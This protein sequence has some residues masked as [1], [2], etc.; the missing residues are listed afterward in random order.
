PFLNTLLVDHTSRANRYTCP[1]VMS[2][3]FSIESRYRAR[4]I[5][6]LRFCAKPFG[7]T[8]TSFAVKYVSTAD[9][10]AYRSSIT[11]PVTSVSSVN[12]AVEYTTTSSRA[13]TGRWSRGPGGMCVLSQHNGPPIVRTGFAGSYT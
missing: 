6:S 10:F 8:S 13:S 4:M 7:Q 5:P 9:D 11:G 2:D 1:G 12:G 3:G